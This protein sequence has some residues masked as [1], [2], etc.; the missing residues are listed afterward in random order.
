MLP[1]MAER[2]DDLAGQPHVRRYIE[3]D[4]EAGHDWHG[5]STLILTTTGRRSG[6]PH[7]TPLIYRRQGDDF[8]VA[9]S[10]GGRDRN[11]AWYHNVLAD[12]DVGVQVWGDRFRARARPATGAERA[13]LWRLMTSGFPRYAD[14]QR[15]IERE[16]PVVVLEPRR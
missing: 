16:I 4:G 13:E 5:A 11:P 7:S 15:A 2:A 1:R 6:E 10:N 3:T 8:V 12:P 9:A 14:Y